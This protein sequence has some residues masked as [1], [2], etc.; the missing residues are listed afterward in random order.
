[1][2]PFDDFFRVG[3]CAA[4]GKAILCK[5][6]GS[7]ICNVVVENPLSLLEYDIH[8]SEVSIL[9]DGGLRLVF[10]NWLNS[11]SRF[12]DIFESPDFFAKKYH[13]D[14]HQAVLFFGAKNGGVVWGLTCYYETHGILLRSLRNEERALAADPTFEGS[15]NFHFIGDVKSDDLDPRLCGAI[16]PKQGRADSLYAVD[17]TYVSTW[18]P[19]AEKLR[20]QIDQIIREVGAKGPVLFDRNVGGGIDVLGRWSRGM[21]PSKKYLTGV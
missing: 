9:I 5:P 1:M 2:R 17:S 6:D 19:D 18:Y 4:D 15:G 16:L 10:V 20:P 7:P 8:T 13:R 12:I 14:E 11:L 21:H 3:C